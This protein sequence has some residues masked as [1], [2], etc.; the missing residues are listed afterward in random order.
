MST[1]RT[2]H[3]AFEEL[4]NR[5]DLAGVTAEEYAPVERSPRR[6]GVWL[7]APVAVAAVVIAAGIAVPIWHGAVSHHTQVA[8]GH[9]RVPSASPSRHP[10]PSPTT[11]QPPAT[12]AALAARTRVILAGTATITVDKSRSS[13]CGAST[14]TLP[15]QPGDCSGADLVGALTSDGHTGGFDLDVSAAPAG[16]TASCETGI[17]CTVHHRADGST[18]AIGHTTV[19]GGGVTY[20]MNYVRADGADILLHLST[21]SDP[22][23]ESPITTTVIPLSQ[24]QMISFVTSDQ[25]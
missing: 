2:L 14:P 21:E 24:D 4:E 18:L 10:S 16:T 11:Y 15:G 7:A 9:A 13:G 20:E 17:H 12:V 6:R 8:T 23:G 3:E 25:W 19:I 1:L 22:K 5:A